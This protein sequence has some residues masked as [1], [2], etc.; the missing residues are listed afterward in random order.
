MI[1]AEFLKTP[2]T[3]VYRHEYHVFVN[4]DSESEILRQTVFKFS[5]DHLN[6]IKLR[7]SKKAQNYLVTVL[8]TPT[9]CGIVMS[10][11]TCETIT[12]LSQAVGC[13]CPEI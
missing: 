7:L 4:T 12:V 6:D 13:H 9:Q 1:K 2:D 5:I 3:S 8:K 11:A 10:S